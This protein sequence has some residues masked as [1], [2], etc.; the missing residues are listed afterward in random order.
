V[1]G[2]DIFN[3][4]R[5]EM[6]GMTDAKNQRRKVL[7]RWRAPGDVTDIPKATPNDTRNSRISTRFIEDGSFLRLKAITLSYNLPGSL[8]TRV[9]I[10]GAKVY[11][12]GE[13][14][15]TFTSYSGF[16]PEVSA[17][18]LNDN[19]TLRNI[20]PGVDYGT[21]PQTRNLIFGLNVSF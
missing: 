1:H 3:A 13:N 4:T 20:S 2:N 8:L 18:G 11:V 12:T 19:N 21:Y 15:L 6:E 5:D 16:D 10:N 17:F 14:L 7:N 9:G